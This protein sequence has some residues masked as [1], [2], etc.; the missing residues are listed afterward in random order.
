MARIP[1][2]TIRAVQEAVDIVEV[3]SRH[4]TLKRSG[5]SF[6]GLCPFHEEKTPSFYVVPDKRLF[7]C[8]GCGEVGSVFAFLMRHQRTSFPE[9]VRELAREYGVPLP[10]VA[11]DAASEESAARRGKALEALRFAAGFFRAVLR[12]DAGRA[13][14]AYLRERGIRDETIDVFDLGYAPD[15]REGLRAYA[16]QKGLSDEALFDAG[17]V[18]RRDDGK[19]YDMFRGRV[20]FP[21]HDAR[22]HIVGFGARALG[23]VQPKY[24]NSPDGP[25]FHKGREIYGLMLARAAALKAGRIVLV[26]GYTDVILSHQAGL[27]EVAAALGTALT[28]ANARTLKRFGVPVVLLYDGDEAG[29]RAAERAADVLLA[30]HVEGF[31]AA[32]PPGQDPADAVLA[33]GA[34]SL[35]G[36]LRG[37]RDL[38]DYRMDRVRARH[39][40]ATLEGRSRAAEELLG[41]IALMAD[42]LRRDVALKLLSERMAVPES[43]LRDALPRRR[44]AFAPA[45]SAPAGERA[46]RGWS[47]AEGDLIAA[48]L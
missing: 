11:G 35:E 18:R 20:T 28:P 27:R 16:L 3:I 15:E 9:T 23:E 26:E 45:V 30:E 5:R 17:L 25:L 21:I 22:E 34:A 37:A 19:P 46:E 38:F 48:V 24:L 31:V 39:D 2:E 1:E 42:P 13:A 40:G 7:K 4:V 47:S 10:E 6:R 32:L 8:F 44:R 36:A 43:T 14:L 12:R 41:T 29:L 33:G